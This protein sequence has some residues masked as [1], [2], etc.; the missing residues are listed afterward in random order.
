[1]PTLGRPRIFAGGQPP[2]D[3]AMPVRSGP[4]I[5][6]AS[7]PANEGPAPTR[8]RPRIFDNNPP[9]EDNAAVAMD[10]RP[11]IFAAMD[12]ANGQRRT[13]HDAGD[14]RQSVYGAPGNGQRQSLY[15]AGTASGEESRRPAAGTERGYL[16]PPA[17]HGVLAAGFH[18]EQE[19]NSRG[20]VYE[21]AEGWDETG[22]TAGEAGEAGV[23]LDD[24]MPTI[25]DGVTSPAYIPQ[26][27][28]D[29]R[30]PDLSARRSM[31]QVSDGG[32]PPTSLAFT[33]AHSHA[34]PARYSVANDALA[35]A[36][37]D[38]APVP[39]PESEAPRSRKTSSG[40]PRESKSRRERHSK[41]D[42]DRAVVDSVVDV[43]TSPSGDLQPPLPPVDSNGL[44]SGQ[45]SRR[46]SM[47][48]QVPPLPEKDGAKRASSKL[49]KPM[50]DGDAAR[51]SMFEPEFT[52][53]SEPGPYPLLA[54]LGEP[55]LLAGILRYL[56][57][58]EWSAL[59]IVS[60][61]VRK[62]VGGKRPLR[63]EVLERFLGVVGYRRWMKGREPLTLY[64][65]VSA[66]FL[67]GFSPCIRA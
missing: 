33:D 58:G 10:T 17:V 6:A 46:Q 12:A 7:P 60:K 41:R 66:S 23:P 22:E 30:S 20:T 65:E 34:P 26:T 32:P 38:L 45:S 9:P 35:A 44:A 1:M 52:E 64:L 55:M 3:G 25:P 15:N 4:R 67:H 57:F 62:L 56:T 8:G 27:L 53:E 49:R 51:A 21:D 14:G 54:H 42:R 2:D 48:D 61:D 39:A 63:E 28:P 29:T 18:G 19:N 16:S 47:Y 43:G 13:L 5:F 11:R 31:V 36:N 50:P 59:F 40:K 24:D 37:E